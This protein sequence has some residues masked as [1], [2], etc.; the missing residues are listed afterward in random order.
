MVE[1]DIP[2]PPLSPVATVIYFVTF[3]LLAGFVILSL[4]ISVVTTAMVRG[5]SI[6][7]SQDEP[8]ASLTPAIA[9]ALPSLRSWSKRGLK[10]RI[11]TTAALPIHNLKVQNS[12]LHNSFELPDRFRQEPKR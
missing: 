12:F 10:R 2:A 7:L 4:F 5:R 3:T 1:S 11:D 6:S 8:R 9:P